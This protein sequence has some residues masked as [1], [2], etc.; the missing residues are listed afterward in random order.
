MRLSTPA[1]REPIV[2]VM[3]FEGAEAISV[4][5]CRATPIP[6]AL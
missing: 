4:F 5:P 1:R 3:R 2:I 6:S